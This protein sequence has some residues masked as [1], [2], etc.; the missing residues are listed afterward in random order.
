MGPKRHQGKPLVM[1]LKKAS[2]CARMASKPGSLAMGLAFVI[3]SRIADCPSRSIS[4]LAA[5]EL[6]DHMGGLGR[7]AA[8]EV[9][10]NVRWQHALALGLVLGDDLEEVLA[11]QVVA[12]LEVHDLHLAPRADEARDVLQRDVVA[13]LGVVEAAAGVA[14]DEERLVGVGHGQGSP[15]CACE[16]VLSAS[17]QKERADPEG[18]PRGRS[19]KETAD[20]HSFVP[21]GSRTRPALC[22][23]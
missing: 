5:E 4:K 13:R 23:L 15:F 12:G 10:E 22:S 19:A 6:R 8:H 21:Q 7:V 11:R 18:P 3:C 17:A 2:C 20:R 1:A 9:G 14:L 16:K